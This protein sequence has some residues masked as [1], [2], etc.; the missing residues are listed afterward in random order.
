MLDG[1]GISIKMKYLVLKIIFNGSF[2]RGEIFLKS[3]C[4]PLG[5]QF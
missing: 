4:E 3:L 5:C 2:E 1:D